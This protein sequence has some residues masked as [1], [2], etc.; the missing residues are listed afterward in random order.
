MAVTTYD[1]KKYGYT[2]KSYTAASYNKANNSTPAGQQ[3]AANPTEMRGVSD[4][5]RAQKAQWQG[6]TPSESVTEAQQRLQQVMAG[7]P[8]GYN[9]KYGAALDGILAQIQNPSGYSYSFANDPLFNYYADMYTQKGKQASMDA[10]GQAAGLTGGYGN[11]Y[12]QAA[13]NQ[14]YNNWLTGLFDKGMELQNAG[15]QRYSDQRTDTYNQ[16]AA[17]QGA[18]DT[19]YS[20]YRDE[21]GDF[22]A[23]RSYYTDRADTEA[24]RDYDRFLQNREYWTGQAAAENADWWAAQEFNEQMRGNDAARQLDYDKLNTENQYRYDDMNAD[25]KYKYDAMNAE[26]QYRYDTLEDDQARYKDSSQLSRDQL[27]EEQRQFDASQAESARQ[28]DESSAEE[29]RQYDQ[30]MAVEYIK[31]ILAMGQTPSAELLAAAGL[32][33]EDYQK[34]LP[35]L[36]TAAAET[37][38]G[39][40][41]KDSKDSSDNSGANASTGALGGLSW[42]DAQLIQNAD[43]VA[44]AV[45]GKD[46][47]NEA[48][49]S[50]KA[51]EQKKAANQAGQALLNV[52]ELVNNYRNLTNTLSG[53]LK[54]KGK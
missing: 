41:T 20:R 43:K 36:Q 25:N 27:A 15:Y 30:K 42:K 31:Q 14:A 10:M 49:A 37:A 32:T 53:S 50:T 44:K 33:L 19:G 13:G 40:Q 5:T 3:V 26:N 22:E 29:K 16:L 52:N 46:T 45:T 35:A 24:D 9:S 54:K 6:Y 17:L 8:A 21:V 34:M 39:T 28:F 23:D 1:P 4:N 51:E 7:R 18:D 11:S 38:A 12:A 2:N 47:M 48:I